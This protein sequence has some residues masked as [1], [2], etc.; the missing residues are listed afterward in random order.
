MRGYIWDMPKINVYLPDD[1]ADAVREAG[2]PV[3]AI[4]QRALEQAVSR[5]AAIRRTILDV[6]E[7]VDLAA[8]LPNFTP[9][10][11]ATLTLAIDRA[12]AAG[13]TAVTTADLLHGILAEGTNLAVQVLT[14]MEIDPAAIVVPSGTEDGRPAAN[15]LELTVTEATAMG[16]NYV[17]CEHLLIALAAEPD[18]LA[19]QVLRD[20]G[21]DARSTRRAVS[22]AVAGYAHLRATTKEPANLL[23][24]ALAPIVQRIEALEARI[25]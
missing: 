1:L 8:Q 22:A 25:S 4:C 12:R 5:V 11:I 13:A 17:G 2:L 19:G 20:A 7:P 21:A 24:A 16:H 10:A 9:R 14:A 18:G 23:Q 6:R 15:A 3:S